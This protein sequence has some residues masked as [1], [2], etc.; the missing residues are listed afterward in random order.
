LLAHLFPNP[1]QFTCNEIVIALSNMDSM[2]DLIQYGLTVSPVDNPSIGRDKFLASFHNI[3]D[4]RHFYPVFPPSSGCCLDSTR[5]LASQPT[6]P[7]VLQVKP[8]ILITP[9]RLQY[10]IKQTKGVLCLNPGYLVKGRTGG[11]YARITVHPLASEGMQ[12]D[13]I[14]EHA[15]SDRSRVDIIR[16]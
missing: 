8:D 2:R 5:A 13:D 16:L 3:L 10:A 7:C 12:A 15:I 14:F 1:V 9:S 6:D 11:T 4:Q